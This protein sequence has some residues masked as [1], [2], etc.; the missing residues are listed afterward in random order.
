MKAGWSQDCEDWEQVDRAALKD[1]YGKRPG[2]L[3]RKGSWDWRSTGRSF[4]YRVGG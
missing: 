1:G 3:G 4:S 2:L